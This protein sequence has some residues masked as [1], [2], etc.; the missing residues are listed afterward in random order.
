MYFFSPLPAA[1]PLP[2]P[3]KGCMTLELPRHSGHWMEGNE[4]FLMGCI[5]GVDQFSILSEDYG[6]ACGGEGILV[7]CLPSPTPCLL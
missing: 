5:V 7:L 1:R 4:P 6:G 2:P 3:P